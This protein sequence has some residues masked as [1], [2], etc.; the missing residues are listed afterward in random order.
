MKD[1]LEPFGELVLYF[2]C[3]ES[4]KDDIYKQELQE[5]A[6]KGVVNA[7]FTAY[8]R[9]PNKPKVHFNINIGQ[10]VMHLV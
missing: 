8:S 1:S 10:N 3:R 5:Y 2:G 4:C 9:E 7:L 6:E